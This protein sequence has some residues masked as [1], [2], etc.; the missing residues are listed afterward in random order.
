MLSD[1]S[2]AFPLAQRFSSYSLDLQARGPLVERDILPLSSFAKLQAQD[3]T[4]GSLHG[5]LVIVIPTLAHAKGQFQ[6]PQY[7]LLFDVFCFPTSSSS[8]YGLM[9]CTS[10]I[11][12]LMSIGVHVLLASVKKNA[13]FFV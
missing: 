8:P 6:R 5:T 10:G 2:F 12:S 13:N 4:Q 11:V 1:A 7:G 9:Q 3:S